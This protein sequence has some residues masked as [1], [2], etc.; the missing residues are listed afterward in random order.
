M[1]RVHA[2]LQEGLRVIACALPAPAGKNPARIRWQNAPRPRPCAAGGVAVARRVS[3][4][5][6]V[7]GRHACRACHQRWAR[8]RR[9]GLRGT[10]RSADALDVWRRQ[11]PAGVE[12]GRAIR[13]LRQSR[14]R[15]VPGA[16][17]RRQS[18]AAVGA[19]PEWRISA[20]VHVRWQASGLLRQLPDLDRAPRRPGWPG[21]SRDAGAVFSRAAFRTN[22]RRSRPTAVGWRTPRT[23]R[24]SARCMS[25]RSPDLPPDRAASGRSPIMAVPIHSGRAPD[26]SWST[27]PAT[28]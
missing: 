25:V 19:S 15:D 16:S 20:V 27:N 6:T 21:E 13:G 24:D 14:S 5:A 2:C 26:A 22:G 18:A 12:P 23:N 9:L 11:Y 4:P 28:S 7:S 8:S 17:G 10:A 3:R 1:A